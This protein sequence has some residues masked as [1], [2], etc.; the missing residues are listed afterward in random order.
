[1]GVT[2]KKSLILKS[3]VWCNVMKM[4]FD[5]LVQQRKW[6]LVPHPHNTIL[7]DRNLDYRVKR[8]TN[9]DTDKYKVHLV[10]KDF[11]QRFELD[12]N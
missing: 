8:E 9:S 4:R 10:T 5:A 6:D 1:M 12:Y 3:L 7:I 2:N 11:H